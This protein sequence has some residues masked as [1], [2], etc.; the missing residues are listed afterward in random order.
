MTLRIQAYLQNKQYFNIF[1]I[2]AGSTMVIHWVMTLFWMVPSIILSEALTKILN[3]Q[4]ALRYPKDFGR[5]VKK[6]AV[7]LRVCKSTTLNFS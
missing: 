4:Y 5:G 2:F 6:L 3:I 7:N 1:S